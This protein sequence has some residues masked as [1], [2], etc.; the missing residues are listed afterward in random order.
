MF[1]IRMRAQTGETMTQTIHASTE[2]KPPF[3]PA[4]PTPHGGGRHRQKEPD[5]P[6]M[7]PQSETVRA[8]ES[9]PARSIPP[10]IPAHEHPVDGTIVPPIATSERESAPPLPTGVTTPAPGPD[11]VFDFL[12]DSFTLPDGA[13]HPGGAK[14]WL[15]TISSKD[16]QI[17]FNTVKGSIPART[18][19]T[20]E[21]KGKFSEY[22]RSAMES[23]AKDKIVSSIA[24]GAALPSKAT[25]AMNDALTKFAQGASD[26]AALQA[27]IFTLLT[28][29]YI[30][31]SVRMH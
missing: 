21:E 22:Q 4:R 13:K 30:D 5:L 14:N 25:N 23:F 12:A 17:A 11:G 18:D 10:I 9:P 2:L 7:P 26:V 8:E 15:N 28:A 31:S 3:R 27:Y 20:D 29:V 6:N 24:H 19:L 16:G 1:T